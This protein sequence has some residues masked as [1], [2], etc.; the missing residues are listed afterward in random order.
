MVLSTEDPGGEVFFLLSGSCRVSYFST[1]G[2]E[3]SFSD[4]GPGEMFGEISAIDD[5][6]RSATVMARI[7]STLPAVV[8][9]TRA[10]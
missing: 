2:R 9:A 7:E 3:V 8:A 1:S 6:G 10:S 4:M 5:Q